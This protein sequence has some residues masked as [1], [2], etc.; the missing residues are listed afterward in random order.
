MELYHK[1]F[2]QWNQKKKALDNTSHI[3]PKFHNSEIWWLSFGTN[4]G[5]EINGKGSNFIR[6]VLI[7]YKINATGFIGIPLT[8][9]LR[10]DRFTFEISQTAKTSCVVLSQIRYFSATRMWN[11]LGVI[12]QK[13]Y[14]NLNCQMIAI[15][16][17][18]LK[19][20]SGCLH[21]PSSGVVAFAESGILYHPK[22]W[23]SIQ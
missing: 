9:K 20:N 23:F 14:R 8:T 18:L 11:K 7:L 13:T 15:F 10:A 6:P 3:P 22:L 19:W 5:H 1:D 2:D 17:E 16:Q 4:I 21:R 12:D